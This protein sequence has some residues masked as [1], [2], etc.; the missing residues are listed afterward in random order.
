MNS[1]PWLPVTMLSMTMVELASV[2]KPSPRLMLGATTF[3]WPSI[4][5]GTPLMLGA[6]FFGVTM[7][8]MTPA[9]AAPPPSLTVTLKVTVWLLVMSVP[10]WV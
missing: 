8:V 6:T 7:M 2:S 4:R 10:L 1:V 5:L 3:T 9:V